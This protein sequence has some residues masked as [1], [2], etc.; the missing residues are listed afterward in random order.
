MNGVAARRL[1]PPQQFP[2]Q[3]SPGKFLASIFWN[4]DD[5]LI[6]NYIPKGQII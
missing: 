2:V 3:K 6:I 4:Q 5:I 1:T